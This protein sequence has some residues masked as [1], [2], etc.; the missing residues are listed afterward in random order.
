[1]EQQVW[2]VQHA[3]QSTLRPRVADPLTAGHFVSSITYREGL[4]VLPR[5]GQL[6]DL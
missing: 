5:P 6:I 4:M 2:S 3:R 1:M